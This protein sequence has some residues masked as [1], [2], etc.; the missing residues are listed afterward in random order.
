MFDNSGVNK[1]SQKLTQ[2]FHN[3]L[4]LLTMKLDS[5][6]QV[7]HWVGTRPCQLPHPSGWPVGSKY[8][9]AL[10]FQE[11]VRRENDLGTKSV[12]MSLFYERYVSFYRTLEIS[13]EMV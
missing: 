9:V 11:R 3:I 13:M 1:N 8:I 7:N 10:P 5:S 6:D 12:G 4:Q 2:D